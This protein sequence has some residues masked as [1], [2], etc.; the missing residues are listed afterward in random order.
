[1]LFLSGVFAP[2]LVVRTMDKQVWEEVNFI[3]HWWIRD[4][5]YLHFHS[6]ILFWKS[7]QNH[8]LAHASSLPTPTPQKIIRGQLFFIFE[9]YVVGTIK[10]KGTQ[11]TL[12]KYM[13]SVHS[14]N[15]S[16]Y[17]RIVNILVSVHRVSRGFHKFS[18]IQELQYCQLR[19][20]C[21][22]GNEQNKCFFTNWYL[23]FH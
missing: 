19:F 21:A 1:M 2:F 7:W 14:S 13:D 20:T 9:E 4:G 18:I 12:G 23:I 8:L 15:G 5:P 11:A 10:T 17:L 16:V 3:I 22:I 6:F